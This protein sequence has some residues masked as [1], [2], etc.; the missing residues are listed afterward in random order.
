[1]A[2]R[3][4]A[5]SSGRS[6]TG[7]R[8][9]PLV[10]RP[11]CAVVSRG[12]GQS[13]RRPAR[14]WPRPPGARGPRQRS[15]FDRPGIGRLRAQ[16][17]QRPGDA[18]AAIGPRSCRS[19]SVSIRRDRRHPSRNR[20]EPGVR[21][22]IAERTT[23]YFD[24]FKHQLPDIDPA[25]TDDWMTSLDQRRRAGGRDPR[26]VPRLQAAQARAPAPDRAAA[27]DPDALHQ[28]D[29]PGAG[30][31]LPGR[32]GDGAADPAD[33]P[34]E[35]RR[36]GPAREQPVPGH[37]R[38]PRRRT[39]ASASLYEVGFNH[40]FRGKDG[41]GRGRPGLLPG[42]RRARDLRARVPRGPP[43]RG[44]A[45]PLPARDRAGRGPAARTRTR[46]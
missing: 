45:R 15:R 46:G 3:R 19:R 9:H 24:E 38:P 12:D 28:H 40:F 7:R 37:R 10:H 25:E 21:P 26:P 31:E 41:D 5:R 1:M 44:P 16:V 22:T 32:R 6:S 20:P 29:Q 18:A 13:G 43:D 14:R 30:A 2:A 23:M 27:A 42:P 17:R 4:T 35:R 34:L 36:D 33:R 11:G 39:P 8:A